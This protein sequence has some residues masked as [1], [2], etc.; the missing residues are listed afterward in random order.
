MDR[1]TLSS[2]K[3]VNEGSW[4]Q[5]SSVNERYSETSN[6]ESILQIQKQYHGTSV[7]YF[8]QRKAI[9]PTLTDLRLTL[10]DWTN[11]RKISFNELKTLPN[12][13]KCWKQ[14]N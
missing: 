14:V 13:I 12:Q 5:S 1:V 6:E 7:D 3:S 8:K 4:E 9:V 2:G 11:H 10:C